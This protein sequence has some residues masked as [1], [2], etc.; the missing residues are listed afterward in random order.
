[1]IE[2]PNGDALLGLTEVA[3]HLGIKPTSL[4]SMRSSGS[5]IDPAG[6]LGTNAP[7]WFRSAVDDYAAARGRG[8]RP[9]KPTVTSSAPTV[10]VLLEHRPKLPTRLR[11]VIGA[12]PS[13]PSDVE[14]RAASKKALPFLDP[15]AAQVVRS[16]LASQN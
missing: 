9:S 10:A 3:E 11:R 15:E 12:W 8:S 16:Y 2:L 4:R 14:V 1:M 7:G 13:A 6:T 5:F